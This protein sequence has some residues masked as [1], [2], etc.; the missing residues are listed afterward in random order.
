MFSHSV[1]ALRRRGKVSVRI[2]LMGGHKADCLV[3]CKA[4]PVYEQELTIWLEE[5]LL[6]NGGQII[7]NNLGDMVASSEKEHRITN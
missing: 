1:L 4:T 2:L 3:N 7:W 5:T 6:G